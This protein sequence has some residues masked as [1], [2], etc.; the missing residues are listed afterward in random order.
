LEQA[1]ILEIA[2]LAAKPG[3][4]RDTPVAMSANALCDILHLAM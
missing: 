3:S 2:G 1:N 4:I